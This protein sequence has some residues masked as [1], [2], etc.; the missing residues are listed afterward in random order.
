MK[1]SD[2]LS[3]ILGLIIILAVGFLSLQ[4][5]SIKRLEAKSQAV[6]GC[7]QYSGLSEIISDTSKSSYPIKDIYTACMADKGY[8]TVW[9]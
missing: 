8:S 2:T 6:D 1:T 5:L 3:S 4:Y 9:K 7:M